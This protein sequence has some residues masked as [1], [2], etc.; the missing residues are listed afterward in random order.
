MELLVKSS[1]DVLVKSSVELFQ[2]ASMELLV[3]SSVELFQKASVELLVKSSVELFQNCLCLG[4][5]TVSD[6]AT[7]DATSIEACC[8]RGRH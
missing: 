2:K 7:A 6:V 1:M 3:K 4:A 5:V 8:A